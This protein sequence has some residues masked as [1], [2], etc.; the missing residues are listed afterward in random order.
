MSCGIQTIR[1]E[2]KILKSFFRS[3]MVPNRESSSY[4]LSQDLALWDYICPA[5]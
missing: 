1:E 4:V 2:G 3:T 5:L